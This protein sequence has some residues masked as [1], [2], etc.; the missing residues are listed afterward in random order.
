MCRC[1]ENDERR[2]GDLSP[3][4]CGNAG[5][6]LARDEDTVGIFG[7]LG[8]RCFSPIASHHRECYVAVGASFN[9]S[10]R[11]TAKL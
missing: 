11:S 5:C 9:T 1:A 8:L 4:I 7:E 3:P 6:R 2:I 10:V